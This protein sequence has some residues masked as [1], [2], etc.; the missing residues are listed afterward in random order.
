MSK[1]KEISEIER[2]KN[3]IEHHFSQYQD[4]KYKSKNASKKDDRNR[5]SDYMYTHANFIER[6][7][8]SSLVFSEISD[9]N[10]FQFENFSRY[11]ESDVPDYLKKIES[12]LERLKSEKDKE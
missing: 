8:H 4:Y 5:A 11:V 6:E 9:Q 2:I 7:L 10:Q 12:L 3:S 1:E